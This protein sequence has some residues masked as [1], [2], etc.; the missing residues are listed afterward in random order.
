MFSRLFISQSVMLLLIAL[1]QMQDLEVNLVK[2][3]EV[4]NGAFIQTVK[5]SLDGIPSF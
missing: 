1:A 5:I 4:Y 3:H 2:N